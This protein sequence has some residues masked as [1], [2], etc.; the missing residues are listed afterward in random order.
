M[1]RKILMVFVFALFILSLLTPLNS[2]ANN[3]INTVQEGYLIITTETGSNIYYSFYHDGYLYGVITSGIGSPSTFF[4][5]DLRTGE[6]IWAENIEIEGE[7]LLRPSTYTYLGNNIVLIGDASGHMILLDAKT[8]E[9]VKSFKF[10]DES[11]A[12]NATRIGFSPVYSTD[13][14]SLVRVYVSNELGYY[15]SFEFYLDLM[16]LSI[17][18]VVLAYSRETGETFTYISTEYGNF[19]LYKNDTKVSIIKYG[20]SLNDLKEGI[21]MNVEGW[22]DFTLGGTGVLEDYMVIGIMN[23]YFLT[24]SLLWLK[25]SDLSFGGGFF[26]SHGSTPVIL[27]IYKGKP[28]SYVLLE[29]GDLQFQVGQEK[30]TTPSDFRSFAESILSGRTC[31]WTAK[32]PASTPLFGFNYGRTG[33]ALIWFM[34]KELNFRSS[35]ALINISLLASDQNELAFPFGKSNLTLIK[36]CGIKEPVDA[37]WISEDGETQELTPNA[38]EMIETPNISF[39]SL[40]K[41]LIGEVLQ[42][43]LEAG[44]LL[45]AEE[46]EISIEPTTAN[47]YTYGSLF[48]FSPAK[49]GEANLETGL[50]IAS[51]IGIVLIVEGARRYGSSKE[52][53]SL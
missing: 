3:S 13:T 31:L 12:P 1:N 19:M 11:S 17:K 2:L 46:V 28:F 42:K 16:T 51:I 44:K 10:Y 43:Q 23:P 22:S 33:P 29:Q 38:S 52:A 15:H 20:S 48:T 53:D 21:V 39:T 50:V 14:Y 5:M 45:K 32:D 6:T 36:S 18:D 4:K 27:S 30:P 41:E 8:G 37:L 24:Y 49:I 34:S 40:D 7:Y 25:N 26:Y 47:I 9:K 35:L